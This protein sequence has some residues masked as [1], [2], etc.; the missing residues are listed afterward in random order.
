MKT[1]FLSFRLIEV[2]QKFTV[3]SPRIR[4]GHLS[5]HTAARG[6]IQTNAWPSGVRARPRGRA[7]SSPLRRWRRALPWGPTHRSRRVRTSARL[8]R[9]SSHARRWD[10]S[11]WL[12][13]RPMRSGS[14]P[15]G[16]WLR[17]LW[18]G[19]MPWA[20][21]RARAWPNSPRLPSG[22]H[23]RRHTAAGGYHAENPAWV[24]ALRRVLLLLRR[25]R[26]FCGGWPTVH[27]VRLP[28]HAQQARRFAAEGGKVSG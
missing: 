7:R 20:H 14:G 13:S 23:S 10:L 24:R 28:A 9:Q 12:R 25:R 16:R 18:A 15:S 19:P 27:A 26:R 5:D 22:W 17:P 3:L 2:F 8:S 11:R 1:N 6:L 21:I 4:S